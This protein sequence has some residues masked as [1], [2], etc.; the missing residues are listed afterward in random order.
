MSWSKVLTNLFHSHCKYPVILHKIRIFLPFNYESSQLRLWRRNFSR[1]YLA[2]ITLPQ[3]ETSR[4]ASL[5]F[6]ASFEL[7]KKRRIRRW[8]CEPPQA[9][10]FQE[11]KEI[12]TKETE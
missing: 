9:P 8:S 3:T 11:N 1:L 10:S 5:S 2:Q 7:V 12:L 4:R 6:V